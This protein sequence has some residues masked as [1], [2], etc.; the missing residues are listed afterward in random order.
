TSRML[1]DGATDFFNNDSWQEKDDL[2]VAYYLVILTV[3]SFNSSGKSFSRRI[4]HYSLPLLYRYSEYLKRNWN[5]IRRSIVCENEDY[6]KLME[7]YDTETTLF[8]LDPPYVKGGK[9]YKHSF[10]KDDFKQLKVSC[11][12]L[13]GIWIMNESQVDFEF[14]ESVFGKPAFVEEYHN[15]GKFRGDKTKTK[16]LEGYWTNFDS[17]KEKDRESDKDLKIMSG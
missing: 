7:K 8:Y 2:T 16:R 12:K 4:S 10:T 6:Q 1:F 17:G 13:K 11:D 3:L 9:N 14:I 5:Y 15:N